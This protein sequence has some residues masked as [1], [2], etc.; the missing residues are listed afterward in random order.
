MFY[1]FLEDTITVHDY[2]KNLRH[3]L[4]LLLPP[5]TTKQ[6]ECSIE[7]CNRNCDNVLVVSPDFTWFATKRK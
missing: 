6:H 7:E 3:I 4:S 2:H 1:I 5:R